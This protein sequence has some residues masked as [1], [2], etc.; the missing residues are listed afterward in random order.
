MWFLKVFG[1]KPFID[2]QI[3]A[4]KFFEVLIGH[5][6]VKQKL[7]QNKAN[8]NSGIFW[9]LPNIKQTKQY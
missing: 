2:L 3:I 4:K 1:R 5:S 6:I 9:F 8:S 7:K